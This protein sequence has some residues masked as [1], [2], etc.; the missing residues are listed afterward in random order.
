MGG[1]GGEEMHH[2]AE[3]EG[4]M[5]VAQDGEESHEEEVDETKDPR[6]HANTTPEEHVYPEQTLTKGGD[7]EVAGREK[8]MR[9]TK[10]TWKNGDNAMSESMGLK[11]MK[12]YEG[13]K[14]KK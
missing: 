11:F 5:V 14:V 2:D 4:I 10:P 1:H 7:G 9:P 8:Q 12:E 13:I 3:P 6:Y